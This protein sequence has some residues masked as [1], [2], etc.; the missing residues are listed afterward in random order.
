MTKGSPRF[1]KLHDGLTAV[2]VGAA[3]RAAVNRGAMRAIALFPDHQP[4]QQMEAAKRITLAEFSARMGLEP[5][6]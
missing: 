6:G 2:D 5:R 3:Y 4:T 1:N